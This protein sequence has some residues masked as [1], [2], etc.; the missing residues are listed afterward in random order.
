MSIPLNFLQATVLPVEC[1]FMWSDILV[2]KNTWPESL[3]GKI[4]KKKKEKKKK[5]EYD[6][7]FTANSESK[8]A[9]EN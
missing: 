6:V 5:L 8:V 4:Y 9:H 1:D 3:E 7:Y 2:F